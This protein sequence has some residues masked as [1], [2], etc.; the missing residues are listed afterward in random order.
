M[1]YQFRGALGNQGKK[2]KAKKRGATRESL[3]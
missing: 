1:T 2:E 3:L